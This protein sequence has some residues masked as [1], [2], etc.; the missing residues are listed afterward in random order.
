MKCDVRGFTLIELMIVIAIIAII[1][2]LALPQYLEYTI[3]SKNGEC[4]SVAGGAKVAVA[5]TFQ[6]TGTM[7]GSSVAAGYVFEPSK[8]CTSVEIGADGVITA[9]TN[10]NSGV[11]LTFAPV[12]GE[13]RLEWSCEANAGAKLAHLPAT[14]R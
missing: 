2:A 9:T 3:R 4:M 13:G 11:V 1:V 6:D 5:E 14:C 7:P 10:T 12:V 8:Y